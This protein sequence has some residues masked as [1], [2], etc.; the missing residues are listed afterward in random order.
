MEV[1]RGAPLIDMRQLCLG[2]Y[3]SNSS[4]FWAIQNGAPEG[5]RE[6]LGDLSIGIDNASHFGSPLVFEFI[7]K[8]AF[9]DFVKNA[10]IQQSQALG[11]LSFDLGV[12][13]CHL[14]DDE[15]E[16]FAVRQDH[17]AGAILG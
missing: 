14:G 13:A 10:R 12:S 3:R 6:G 8:P 2:P 16:T 4:S 5:T 17:D 11:R 7:K 15:F 9:F 1:M